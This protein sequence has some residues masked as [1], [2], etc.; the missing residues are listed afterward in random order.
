MTIPHLRPIFPSTQVVQ[1]GLS[2]LA[3]LVRAYTP[4]ITLIY[5]GGVVNGLTGSYGTYLMVRT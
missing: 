2:L 3:V 1:V 5:L 4:A